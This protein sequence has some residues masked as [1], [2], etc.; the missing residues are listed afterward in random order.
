MSAP[1]DDTMEEWEIGDVEPVL[2]NLK[3]EIAI[4]GHLINTPDEVASGTWARLEDAL[5]DTHATLLERW[6]GTWRFQIAERK[7]AMEALDAAKAERA[8]PGS[9]HDLERAHSV[10]GLL[11]AAAMVTLDRCA[12]IEAALLSTSPADPTDAGLIA[13]CDQLVDVS[14]RLNALID[15]RNTVE[16]EE[17]TEAQLVALYDERREV[18]DQIH[19]APRLQSDQ[20]RDALA[21]AALAIAERDT[22]GNITHRTKAASLAWMVVESLAPRATIFADKMPAASPDAELIALCDRLV[23]INAAEAALCEAIEDA[24]NAR[25]WKSRSR[26]NGT[27]STRGCLRSAGQRPRPVPPPPRAPRR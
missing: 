27:R 17:R 14:A 23:A 25:R 8:A 1:D 3:A 4:L 19:D 5:T 7:A 24:V 12:E 18:V 2:H 6:H 20:G 13:L 21:R 22:E 15:T 10:W 26:L 9:L 16:D 11:R